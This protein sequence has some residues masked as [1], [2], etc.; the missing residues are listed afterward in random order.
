MRRLALLLL[1]GCAPLAAAQDVGAWRVGAAGSFVQPTQGMADRFAGLATGSVGVGQWIG[2]GLFLEGRIEHYAFSQGTVVF[3]APIE[4]EDVNPDLLGLGL[5][6]TGGAVHVQ[7]S[8]FSRWGLRPFATGGIGMYHWQE[9]RTAYEDE[10]RSVDAL[11]RPSQWSAGF[12][13]G[14]GTEVLVARQVALHAGAHYSVV[15]GELWPTLAL[16]LENVSTFQFVN[17]S[18]GV[19]YT[20]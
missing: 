16:G 5:D 1:L 8:L 3:R 2:E 11:E 10:H 9:R 4:G 15:M 20:L 13:A 7:R 19:R 14:L 17:V 18:L 6:L 12:H